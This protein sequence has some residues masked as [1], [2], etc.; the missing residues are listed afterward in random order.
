MGDF[1]EVLG[2]SN[3]LIALLTLAVLEIVLGIDNI[4]FLSIIAGRAV[5]EKQRKVRLIGLVMAMFLRI[6]MLFGISW[7]VHVDKEVLMIAGQGFSIKD[8]ILL[9]GGMFLIG[10][11]TTEIHHKLSSHGFMSG[12]ED[13]KPSG[14]KMIS[15]LII[16]IA[17]INIIF[18]LDSLLTAVGLTEDVPTM[19]VA[20]VISTLFMMIFA[21]I[22]SDFINDNPTIIMLALAF[23]IM[24]GTLLIA[25]ALHFHVPRGYVYFAMGFSLFVEVLNLL[26]LRKINRTQEVK[27]HPGGNQDSQN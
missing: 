7:L 26:L 16:Q 5:A 27:G 11:S 10:K 25:D 9:I 22:V 17:M 20:I 8:L 24:I 14:L 4:V 12:K 3:G 15:G 18:S 1:F 13:E 19:I 23:L 6:L 21:G 2:T